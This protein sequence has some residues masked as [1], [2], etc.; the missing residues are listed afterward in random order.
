MNFWEILKKLIALLK[1]FGLDNRKIYDYLYPKV[2][3][4]V[5]KSI[6]LEDDKLE[7]KIEDLINGVIDLILR[8]LLDIPDDKFIALKK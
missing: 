5:I 6:D 7:K 2:R 4:Y 8:T 3:D 1:L